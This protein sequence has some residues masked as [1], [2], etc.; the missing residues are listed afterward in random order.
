M[1]KKYVSPELEWLTLEQTDIIA[2]S[3]PGASTGP[4][5]GE[6]DDWGDDW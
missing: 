2:I 5:L 6:D 4:D 3:M 1:K